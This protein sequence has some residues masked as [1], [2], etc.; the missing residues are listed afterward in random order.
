MLDAQVVAQ[1]LLEL[2]MERTTMVNVLLAQI[3]SR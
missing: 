3:F 2:V 1:R